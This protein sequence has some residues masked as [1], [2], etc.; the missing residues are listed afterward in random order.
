MNLDWG[1][2]PVWVGIVL[3]SFSVVI[4]VRTYVLNS[5]RALREQASQ[6][7]VTIHQIPGTP[8]IVHTAVVTNYSKAPIWRVVLTVSRYTTSESSERE[9]VVAP[10]DSFS[11]TTEPFWWEKYAPGAVSGAI[12]KAPPYSVVKFVDAQG[13]QWRRS[14]TGVLSPPPYGG[15][16]PMAQNWRGRWGRRF[17]RFRKA[18]IPTRLR[19]WFRDRWREYLSAK[20]KQ[21]RGS[22]KDV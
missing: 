2:V 21:Y 10:D 13:Y 20:P 11:F 3:T 8:D 12:S 17:Y 22:E 1:N 4:A 18:V 19:H 7:M 9:L 5:R 6:V 15:G 16:I 14:S